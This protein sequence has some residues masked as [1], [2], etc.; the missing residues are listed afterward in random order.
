VTGSAGG[1]NA[2]NANSQ[3]EKCE[4][5]FGTVALVEETTADWYRLFTQS[6]NL[7][8]TVPVLRLMIQ[9]SNCF[10]IVERGRAFQNMERE[11]A[12]ARSG[13]G[14]QGSNFGQGQIV[15]A[16]YSIT[17]EVIISARGTSG[18]GGGAAGLL[19]P[20]GLLA[21]AVAG[22]I[23]TNEAATVLMLIDNRSGVQVSAAQGSASNTDFNVGAVLFG[24]AGAV[25]AGAYT[26]TPQGKVVIAAFTD[27]YN[28]IVR[29]LKNYVPQTVAGQGLGTGGKLAVDG[30]KPE[31][32]KASP[33]SGPVMPVK[34]AQ[35]R[36]NK[37]G[38]KAGTPDGL[39]GR[40]TVNALKEFQ[41]DRG[42]P[43]TGSLD[44]ATSQEL[45]K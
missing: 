13:E 21:G 19:G 26:N 17:P 22:G 31:P 18:V 35:E 9:Q 24:G 7:G 40:G 38:Y 45:K 5:P 37:L 28:G 23:K 8:S 29:A 10:I 32:P 42:L 14:R 2:Q 20:I 44:F 39:L 25:G 15:A 43:T 41:K 4:R 3:L 6:Y 34:E 1:A 12:L 30:A 33:P 27:S 16:D 11:R 36:L